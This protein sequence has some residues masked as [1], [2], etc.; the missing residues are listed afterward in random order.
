V[1]GMDRETFGALV[2]PHRRELLVHCYRMSGSYTDAEDHVQETFLRAWRAI[3]R[4]EGRSSVRTWLYRIATNICL[5]ALDGRAGRILPDQLT[6]ETVAD[7]HWLEPFPEPDDAAVARE[8]VELTLIVAVQHLPVRQR[9]VLLLRDALGWPAADTAEL[10][11]TSVAAVNSALQ[12]ARGTVRDH[13]PGHRLNWAPPAAPTGRELAVVRRYMDAVD[14]A[15]LT[16]VAALLAEDV[17][18]TMPPFREW[19]DNRAGVLAALTT[20]WDPGSPDY[21]GRMR[22]VPTR[23]N[24]RP[25]LAGYTSPDGVTYH[26]FAISVFRVEGDRVAGITAFHDTGLF[27]SFALPMSFSAGERLPGQ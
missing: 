12:R 7:V 16:A 14:R 1:S 5:D 23:A 19:F 18:A 9:A 13:L 20:S 27:P 3:D 6:D 25:A 15:D 8:T 22:A 2:E 26:A 4:F 11:D 21:I 24:G 17:R 10:L